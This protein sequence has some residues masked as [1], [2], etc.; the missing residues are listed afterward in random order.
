MDEVLNNSF[1]KINN[2]NNPLETFF[3]KNNKKT[4]IKTITIDRTKYMKKEISCNPSDLISV[5]VED[6]LEKENNNNIQ[7]IDISSRSESPSASVAFTSYSSSLPPH[8]SNTFDITSRSSNNNKNSSSVSPS[9]LPEMNSC[10]IC[11]FKFHA[12]DIIVLVVFV[13]LFSRFMVFIIS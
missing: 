11:Q 3:E 12:G 13:Y 1:P 6:D 4:V 8:P 9:P 5:D 10:V 2:S 7:P